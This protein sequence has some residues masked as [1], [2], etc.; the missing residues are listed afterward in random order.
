MLGFETAWMRVPV[1]CSFR[2]RK[3]S[4]VRARGCVG[5]AFGS[6]RRFHLRDKGTL[7]SAPGNA[8]VQRA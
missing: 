2:G 1:A 3:R 6:C 7:A 4:R 5:R 8:V